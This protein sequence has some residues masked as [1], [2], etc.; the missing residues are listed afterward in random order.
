MT[1]HTLAAGS[2]VADPQ[3][4]VPPQTA[5]SA[6]KVLPASPNVLTMLPAAIRR[7]IYTVYGLLALIG[8]AVTAYY[9][10]LPNLTVPPWV[11]GGLAVLGALA[12]PISV[13]AVTNVSDHRDR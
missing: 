4:A 1:D 10:A 7:A 2:P 5:A 8:T 6:D 3:P 9:G 11:S 13:L 12:A